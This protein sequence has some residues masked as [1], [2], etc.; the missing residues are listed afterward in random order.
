M[1]A[2][3][4][5]IFQMSLWLHCQ[6]KLGYALDFLGSVLHFETKKL[7]LLFNKP[8]IGRWSMTFWLIACPKAMS[9]SNHA[10]QRDFCR[11]KMWGWLQISVEL[12]PNNQLRLDRDRLKLELEWTWPPSPCLPT[13]FR[14]K[15]TTQIWIWSWPPQLGEVRQRWDWSWSGS[16][17]Q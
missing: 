8:Y 9:L 2:F 11:Q 5:S 13:K 3:L 12:T 14:S 1:F 15:G 7:S 16:P 6:V 17:P 10:Q 4:L